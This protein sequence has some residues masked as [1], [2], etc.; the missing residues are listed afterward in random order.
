MNATVHN[1]TF[2]VLIYFLKH[3]VNRHLEEWQMS[4]DIS[5]ERGKERGMRVSEGWRARETDGS[6][7]V[8]FCDLSGGQYSW[9]LR[10]KDWWRQS[11]W[12]AERERNRD[13]VKQKMKRNRREREVRIVSGMSCFWLPLASSPLWNEKNLLSQ[14]TF[15]HLSSSTSL[16]PFL[17][18]VSS[19]CHC[20]LSLFL[21]WVAVFLCSPP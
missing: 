10:N 3:N 21:E 19:L 8:T 18:L 2:T 13:K 9:T 12:E 17:V 14:S 7:K 6:E 5:T 11:E 16:C 1:Q 20:F 4:R 15:P